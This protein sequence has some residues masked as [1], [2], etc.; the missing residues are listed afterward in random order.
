VFA[1]FTGMRRTMPGTEVVLVVG[2]HDRAVGRLPTDLGI[3]SCLRSLDEPPFHFV[4]APATP[5]PDLDHDRRRFT[6]AGHLH[7]TVAIGTP[8]GD[9]LTDRCFVAEPDLLVLPAFG[10]FTGGH[11]VTPA[12]GLRLWI[13]RDDGVVEVTRLARAAWRC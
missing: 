13:A 6:I 10:S 2:N 7:P 11:R 4:H 12:D 5:L 1:E 3:D 9:R 8:G